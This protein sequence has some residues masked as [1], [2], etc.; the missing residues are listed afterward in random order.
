[1]LLLHLAVVA[2]VV[3]LCGGV[4]GW[5]TYERLGRDAEHQALS[6]ARSV[7]A[8][9]D[10]RAEVARLK[11]ASP[12]DLAPAVLAVGPLQEAAED[13]RRR[14]GS[15][16]VVIFDDE[17][18]RLS[19]PNHARLG[20]RVS[21]DPSEP[22]AG[23]EFTGQARGTLGRSARAKV[24]VYAPGSSEEVVGGVN[25][26]FSRADVLSSLE[27]D[28]APVA[29]TAVGALALGAAAST[30]IARR[31]KRLTL[32]LE[33]EEI[34][35]L[36]QD[37][38]A[39]LRG[40]D[41]GVIGISP[42]HRITV[43]NQEAGRL[44]GIADPARLVGTPLAEAGLPDSFPAL[45]AAATPA[46]PAVEQV[47]GPHVLILSARAVRPA[48]P[49]Q[50]G[51]GWV[52]LVRD[53][54]ELQSLT[55][56]LD[57]VGALSTALRAQRHEFANRLH[58]ISGLLALGDTDEARRYVAE[59]TETG[60]LSYPAEQAELLRDP[61]LQAFLGAKSV[62]AAERGVVL[63]I[64]EDTLVRGQ[65]TDPQDVTTVIGNLV[66]NAVR[67]AVQGAA[68]DR[69]VEVELLDEWADGTGTLHLVVA[70][71]GDGLPVADPEPVFAQGWSTAAPP[72]DGAVAAPGLPEA[73]GQGF[74]L[75]LS[76]E[77]ARRRGGDVWVADRGR[78]GGPGAV[79][80]ARLPGT[81]VPGHRPADRAAA[82]PRED[83]G[84]APV[85]R[86]TGAGSTGIRA[87]GP[88]SGGAAGEAAGR[89]DG[90][91]G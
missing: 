21:T 83:G 15:L 88:R 1:M 78:P 70:D 12:G 33:P 89:A 30:A 45:L 36:V 13:V 62:E 55:R 73:H 71:S 25:V 22:L 10:V 3:L 17:G 42:G 68:E 61:Y 57:A 2:A 44:L 76:R 91:T 46:S 72:A 63:R 53:R 77:L 7:A 67:A 59:V 31:L 64:G 82:G 37:Q 40:V 27:E 60:P 90:G 84:P 48:G 65:I 87:A 4:Y 80:C 50:P 58:T 39:V 85:P 35:E 29:A 32:G 9:D 54:T 86:A 49:G 19:H 43:V 47:V 23:R 6:I 8:D 56:Q 81:V 74:G 41:E 79:F 20:E 14:T 18:L 28:I 34:T 5:L 11:E 24:P 52:V 51:L 26:G 75:P 69:W 66:D 16:F 38:E